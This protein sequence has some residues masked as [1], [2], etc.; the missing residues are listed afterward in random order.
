MLEFKESKFYKLLQEFFI[1]NDKE[2]FLQMLAE[3]YNKTE[4][5]IDKNIIQDELI[6]E[7]RE[8]YIK[9]NEEGIDENIVREKVN[10]FVEN[11]EKIQDIITKIFKNTN[12]IKN[13]TSQLDTKTKL[14]N[15]G[16]DIIN[17]GE[18]TDGN[19]TGKFYVGQD[20]VVRVL[21]LYNR[22]GIKEGATH[23]NN[24]GK[25]TFVIHHYND[26]GTVQIDNV[27]RNNFILKLKNARN[28]V[29]AKHDKTG[30][31]DYIICERDCSDL[32]ATAS[33]THDSSINRT[34]NLLTNDIVFD[35]FS[36]CIYKSLTTRQNVDLWSESFNNPALWSYVDGFG[37]ETLL[38]VKGVNLKEINITSKD[39]YVPAIIGRLG[40]RFKDFL[41]KSVHF[42]T[43]GNNDRYGEPAIQLYSTNKG[44]T[45]LKTKNIGNSKGASVHIENYSSETLSPAIRV[46]GK[47]TNAMY[48]GYNYNNSPY[49]VFQSLN[50]KNPDIIQV[51][52][53]NNDILFKISGDGKTLFMKDSGDGTLK[54]IRVTNGEITIT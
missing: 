30:S 25:E 6:K 40:G 12:N 2:T 8:L 53:K 37:N 34:V 28:N 38:S 41:F 36:N 35:K 3:F 23:T 19:A 24:D 5:I 26:K 31:G 1:N 44:G 33:I 11:N 20:G 16:I 15:Y 42:F 9:F 54:A 21:E 4:G 43:Q 50:E 39:E 49:Q 45:C 14:N 22:S 7:L 13:I 10:Y 29:Q 27:G 17:N 51:K 18:N 32:K 47:S 46:D 52:D 48:T